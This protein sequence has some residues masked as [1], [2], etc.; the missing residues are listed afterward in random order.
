MSN[1]QFPGESRAPFDVKGVRG[2]LVPVEKAVGMVIPHDITEIVAGEKKG[3][4]FKKGH[5]IGNE[6][7][8]RLKDL[9]KYHIYVLDL[10]PEMIHENQAGEIIAKTACGDGVETDGKVSEG[11]V[12]FRA[13]VDGL[14]RVDRDRLLQFNMLGDVMLAT[15]HDNSVVAAGE[16]V[17]AGR[18]IPL[19]LPRATMDKASDI[20]QQAAGLLRVQPFIIR[21][22]AIVVT[23]REIHEGRIED[24]FGPVMS[25][26][27]ARYGVDVISVEKV[28][29]DISMISDKIVDAITSGAELVI[30]TGG[31]SVDPDD[32]TRVAIERAGAEDITYGSPVLP[33]AMFLISYIGDLPVVGIPAC[34]MYFKNTV[35]DL[36]LPRLLA[37][38]RVGRK[39]IARLG[40]GGLCIGC[41]ECR[42][43]VCPFGKE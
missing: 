10:D 8:E 13:S 12:V 34:G 24:A 42:F 15:L 6:D 28:P 39:E 37:G 14:F 1:N 35:F 7:V 17:A 3:P 9:G 20:L 11:K 29:D 30:C 23:G 32:V 19:V 41:K 33:G 2:L 22:A 21:K 38:Q 5:V 27:L 31:M 36:V 16:Q 43:P 18:A 40:H 26:K 4:A 25:K